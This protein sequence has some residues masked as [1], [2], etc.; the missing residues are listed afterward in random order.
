MKMRP[1]LPYTV[2]KNAPPAP[3]LPEPKVRKRRKKMAKK[4]K[5][6]TE[7][8]SPEIGTTYDPEHKKEKPGSGGTVHELE[9]AEKIGTQEK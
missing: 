2:M 6:L 3:P 7:K 9:L 4:T 1:R 5:E 8:V